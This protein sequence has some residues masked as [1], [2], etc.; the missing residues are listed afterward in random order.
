MTADWA[1]VKQSSCPQTASSLEESK[2]WEGADWS[3]NLLGVCW[4]RQNDT[5]TQEACV[6]ERRGQRRLPHL[7]QEGF[8]LLVTQR[9][10][11]VI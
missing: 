11:W 9:H 4:R 7:P 8:W 2:V 10:Y 5:G 3:A 1:K 6:V